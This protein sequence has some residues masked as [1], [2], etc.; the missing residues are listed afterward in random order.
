M[1]LDLRT[2]YA[3]D[4]KHP[5]PPPTRKIIHVDM[6]CF[7]AAVEMRDSPHLKN[8][9]LAIGSPP[10]SRGVIS[11]A[12]Y[13]ARQYGVHSGMPSSTAY[14]KCK[15]LI[16]I[17]PN[18]DKYSAVTEQIHKVFYQYSDKI[19][20]L[21]LDEAFIDV[22][23]IDRCLGSATWMA[24]EITRKIVKETGLTASAGIAPNK[25][26]A[27]VGSDWNKPNGIFTIAPSDILSFMPKLTVDKI[28]GVG[29]VTSEKLNALGIKDCA[30]LQKQ[31]PNYLSAHFGSFGKTLFDF[32]F[33]LD[34][35]EVVTDFVRKS[36]SVEETY[37][38]D[39]RPV[40]ELLS[41]MDQLKSELCRRLR[42]FKENDQPTSVPYKLFVKLKTFDFQ[43]HTVETS[44]NSND[45]NNLWHNFHFSPALSDLARNLLETAYQRGQKAVRLLGIGVRL[46]E[47]P[48][49]PIQL[50][51]L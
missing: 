30:D 19:E 51:F 34:E 29:K 20:P 12:N 18:F 38:Q 31:D 21:S 25:F 36:L 1:A 50:R 3:Y 4:I 28:P 17:P 23:G 27:K 6:D 48:T 40:S 49:G 45:G 5:M 26:L 46:K 33:G 10:G 11:T 24:Q 2:S 7:F 37:P 16:F 13:L 42:S 22:T 39:I 41:K 43:T 14:A 35:R 32:A 15:K 47:I 9:P 44:F 8:L